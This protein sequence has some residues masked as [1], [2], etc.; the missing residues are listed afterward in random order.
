MTQSPAVLS[1]GELNGQFNSATDQLMIYDAQGVPAINQGAKELAAD[2]ATQL[3]ERDGQD[4][5]HNAQDSRVTM[6]SQELLR[7]HAAQ[8]A[9][10]LGRIARAAVARVKEGSSIVSPVPASDPAERG[11]WAFLKRHAWTILIFASV[12]IIE[13]MVGIGVMNQIFSL[14]DNNARIMAVVTPIVSMLIFF[15]LAQVINT[16]KEGWR[17]RAM[18]GF[19]IAAA[20]LMMT[21]MVTS[22]LILSGLIES[23]AVDTLDPSGSGD[24]PLAF[25]WAKLVAYASLMLSISCLVAAA[26]LKDLDKEYEK[27]RNFVIRQQEAAL[28]PLE[29]ALANAERLNQ[30]ID[31]YRTLMGARDDIIA[32]FVAGVNRHLDP[33]LQA[34]WRKESVFDGPPEPEWVAEIRQELARLRASN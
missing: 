16:A 5:L 30:Y 1:I 31:A 32:S 18:L 28:T 13:Y 8:A 25:R 23:A 2:L 10:N 19:G 14:T 3:G 11:L 7:N 26:H 24:E 27:R 9:E 15:I 4:H 34:V 6:P 20:V 29:M 12:L 33:A 22:G 17:K 21:Y